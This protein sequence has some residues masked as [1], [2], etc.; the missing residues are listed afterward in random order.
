MVK[1][2]PL[3]SERPEAADSLSFHLLKR[4][5]EFP[6]HWLLTVEWECVFLI[7]RL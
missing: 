3:K 2:G 5:T 1:A 7:E 4:V 6:G